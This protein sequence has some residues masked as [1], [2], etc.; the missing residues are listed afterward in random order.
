[1]FGDSLFTEN[2]EDNDDEI[3]DLN[4]ILT[5]TDPIK[6]NILFKAFSNSTIN[7]SDDNIISL[8]KKAFY[9]GIDINILDNDSNTLL[10]IALMEG[11]YN[12]A[13]FLIEGGANPNIYTK[14]F[15]F[16][17][18]QLI[19]STPETKEQ[20]DIA[21]LLLKKGADT[22]FKDPSK[23]TIIQSAT[24]SGYI[25]IVK[26]LIQYGANLDVKGPIDE[27]KTLIEFAVGNKSLQ[28]FL[29]LTIAYKDNNFGVIDESVTV[30]DIEEFI[31]WKVSLK[32]TYSNS[33]AKACFKYYQ[34]LDNFKKF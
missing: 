16:P 20:I 10:H 27:S 15:N 31:L 14:Y 30:K 22:E 26:L 21:E 28:S 2:Y 13:K 1:M 17:L 12:I 25:K 9:Q 32:P 33:N 23:Y 18:N 6:P 24:F 3:I 4:K 5:L 19:K 8:F 7:A 34:E 11:F 29:K